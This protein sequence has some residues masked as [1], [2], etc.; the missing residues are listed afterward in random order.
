[1]IES[2]RNIFAIPDLRK[3]V[4]F[5]FL[6]LAVYRLGAYIPTPGVDPAAIAEFTKAASGT[7][8]GFLNLF[9]G[10]SLGRMTI[11]ALGIMPYISASIIL[12]LLTVVWPYLEKLSKEGELGRKKITQWTRYGTVAISLVQSLGISFFLERSSAPGG[13]PLDPTSV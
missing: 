5:T 4:I 13:L 7:I 8:L 6:L 2:I 12:Q 3:R 9:S 1:M 11:F 10:G